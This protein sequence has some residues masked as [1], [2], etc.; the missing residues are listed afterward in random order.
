VRLGL[1]LIDGIGAEAAALIAAHQ[2]FA[3]QEEVKQLLDQDAVEALIRVGALGQQRR[4]RLWQLWAREGK[5]PP[6]P[7]QTPWEELVAEYELM[8]L[9]PNGHPM[10]YFEGGIDAQA[11]NEI[12]DGARVEVAG[13]L[14]CKQK[15]PTAKGFA[16]LTLEDSAGLINV[17][18][19]PDVY[20][21]DKI[22]IKKGGL[23]RVTGTKLSQGGVANLRA[24]HLFPLA[25]KL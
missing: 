18:V 9:S 12:Q 21:R 24:R 14:V 25:V 23:L 22:T 10:D 16:F 8:G 13:L 2:P 1:N 17:I 11:L 4:D 3:H 7:K 5:R 19:P 20:Q 6:L 15:P